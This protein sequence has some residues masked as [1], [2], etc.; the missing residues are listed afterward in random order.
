MVKMLQFPYLNKYNQKFKFE[1]RGAWITVI[2]FED[3]QIS[4]REASV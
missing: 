3:Q 4:G 2:L 1:S